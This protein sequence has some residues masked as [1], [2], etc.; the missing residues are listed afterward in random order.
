MKFWAFSLLA[1]LLC[2]CSNSTDSGD[3]QVRTS[4]DGK[5]QV[6][7]AKTDDARIAAATK[8][9]R[10]RLPEF[11]KALK[12]PAL[13]KTCLLKIPVSDGKTREFMWITDVTYDTQAFFGT[14]VDDAFDVS[15]PYKKGMKGACRAA[16][17]S[18]WLYKNGDKKVGGFTNKILEDLA[19][20]NPKNRVQ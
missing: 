10:R 6:I 1:L 19:A 16:D 9:A 20:Q 13:A 18:D 7:M 11:I 3:G 4:D 17:I 5:S 12:N 14:F 15:G 8:E 2:G